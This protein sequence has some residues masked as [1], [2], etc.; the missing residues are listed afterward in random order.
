MIV[1]AVDGLAHAGKRMLC[2][3]L[4]RMT[5]F[6]FGQG[7]DHLTVQIYAEAARRWPES[8]PAQI[9]QIIRSDHDFRSA[10]FAERRREYE[11]HTHAEIVVAPGAY[12]EGAFP[13]ADLK[14]FVATSKVHRLQRARREEMAEWFMETWFQDRSLHPDDDVASSSEWWDVLIEN[15]LNV[16]DAA[17]QGVSADE[18]DAS[19]YPSL[20]DGVTPL[21][22]TFGTDPGP[23]C[24]LEELAAVDWL[25]EIRPT[26]DD[27]GIPTVDVDRLPEFDL[28]DLDSA[29]EA[30]LSLAAMCRDLADR[31]K[32]KS[33]G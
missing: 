9:T 28:E 14:A 22:L 33:G 4:T 23:L 32:S 21:A 18:A 26:L 31:R 12:D 17:E 20:P 6:D 11:S 29:G 25:K 1:I 19:E 7:C 13:D 5:G 16:R 15:Y 27:A 8:T 24:V 30:A 2:W 3:Q 10:W